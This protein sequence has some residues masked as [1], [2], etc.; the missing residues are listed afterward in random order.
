MNFLNKRLKEIW[1]ETYIERRKKTSKK[2]AEISA[3]A[4]VYSEMLKMFTKRKKIKLFE[5]VEK[6]KD[7]QTYQVEG[8][9]IFVSMKD[10]F[11]K[12]FPMA[13]KKGQL[14]NMSGAFEREIVSK[15]L[16]QKVQLD[17]NM[18]YVI[19]GDR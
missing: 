6:S 16:D 19:N 10:R 4:K 2:R 1:E 9:S 3:D 8:N 11:L 17:P 7:Y 12:D 14:K 13:E 5:V 15:L 18:Y